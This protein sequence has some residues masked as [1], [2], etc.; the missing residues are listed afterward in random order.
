MYDHDNDR[1][2][3]Y[4]DNRPAYY[5]STPPALKEVGFL[6]EA[7]GE[8]SGNDFEESLSEVYL[9]RVVSIST[10]DGKGLDASYVRDLVA[11]AMTPSPCHCEHDCCGHRHG[12]AQAQTLTMDLLRV[13]VRSARNF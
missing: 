5:T 9:V 12:F 6:I 4:G 7:R 2:I 13:E 8:T 11:R 10:E 1:R 3:Y